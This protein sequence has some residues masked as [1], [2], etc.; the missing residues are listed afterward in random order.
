MWHPSFR[1]TFNVFWLAKGWLVHIPTGFSMACVTKTHVLFS[2]TLF[3]V[4]KMKL[5]TMVFYVAFNDKSYK[6]N[7]KCKLHFINIKTTYKEIWV[8]CLHFTLMFILYVIWF[9]QYL[10]PKYLQHL[11]TKEKCSLLLD[12]C[13]KTDIY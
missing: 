12:E 7:W 11:K 8:F 2:N 3:V 6:S 10:V 1:K 13:L 5:N 9:L 4:N